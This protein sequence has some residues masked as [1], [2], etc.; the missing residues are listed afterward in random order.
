M[1]R[2]AWEKW[3]SVLICLCLGIGGLWLCLRYALPLVLPFALAW[4]ASLAVRPMAR[5]LSARIGLS[6]RVCAALLLTLLLCAGVGVLS[7]CVE[8][9]LGE[10]QALLE[11]LLA[12]GEGNE[13]QDFDLYEL[14]TSKIG[15]L[16]RLEVGD[17]FSAFRERFNATA[18]EMLTSLLTSLSSRLPGTVASV[19]S[20]LPSMLLSTVVTIVASFYL[21]MAERETR[22]G[23]SAWL[24]P[25][26][27]RQIPVWKARMKRVSWRY[28][29]AYLLLQLLT[30]T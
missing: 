15:F 27:Q 12:L 24:P 18:S 6:K 16:Q 20:A 22:V 8:R 19:A 17:R 3:A 13:L 1:G 28:L 11:R 14:L 30:L 26:V 4:A 9:L 29:R 5:R 10:L 23:G 21:C 7:L 25:S 2:I